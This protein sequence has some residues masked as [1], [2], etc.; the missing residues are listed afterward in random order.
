MNNF[1]IVFNSYIRIYIE[2]IQSELIEKFKYFPLCKNGRI[3]KDKYFYSIKNC[4]NLDPNM[5]ETQTFF[6]ESVKF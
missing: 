3:R 2:D 1:D 4:F 6:I 5:I